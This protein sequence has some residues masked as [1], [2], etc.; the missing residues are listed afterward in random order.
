[1]IPNTKDRT[2][3]SGGV[4]KSGEFGIS[5]NDAAHIMTILRDTLYS[6][7]V[8]AVIR[9]YSANAWD[10]HRDSGI[11]EKPIKIQLPTD[12]DP[13]LRIRD[14]GKGLSQS[15]V[16]T[17]YTQYGASTKR[18]SDNSVGMLG[19]GSKSG[20]AYS[21]SFNITSWHG[22]SKR[23]YVAVLDKSEKGIIQQLHEEPCGEETGVE[24][25]LAIKPEDIKEFTDK[26]HELFKYFRPRPDIN[27]KLPEL[28]EAQLELKNG[29]IYD[30]P[31]TH[32]YYRSSNW[33]A[34]MGCVFYKISLEQLGEKVPEFLSNISGALFFNIGDVQINASREELKYSDHT[35]AALVAKFNLVVD[36][37]VSHTL[38]GIMSGNFSLWERRVKAQVFKRLKLPVPETSKDLVSGSIP[39]KQQERK[40][41]CFSIYQKKMGE[42]SSSISVSTDTRLIIRNDNKALTGYRLGQHDYIVQKLGQTPIAK[43]ETELDALIKELSLDGITIVKSSDVPWYATARAGSGGKMYNPKHRLKVFEYKGEGSGSKPYSRLWEGVDREPEDTDLYVVLEWFEATGF[44]SAAHED[45]KLAALCEVKIPPVYGYKTTEKHPVE[46]DELLGTHYLKWRVDW[47]KTLLTPKIRM[48]YNQWKWSKLFSNTYYWDE[49][50][51]TKNYKKVVE[52]V[53]ENHLIARTIKRHLD[54]KKYFKSKGI[55]NDTY[56]LLEKRLGDLIGPSDVDTVLASIDAKYPLF[57]PYELSKLWEEHGSK[58]AHYVKIIDQLENTNASTAVHS[59]ERVLDDCLGGKEPHSPEVL[60]ELQTAAAGDP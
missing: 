7:K 40:N 46:E 8:L 31:E 41:R 45:F 29:V 48:S 55:L 22:G 60:P 36:E 59:D 5:L 16:F 52:H 9:E 49:D 23:L 6:D 1:M 24:I 57:E 43:V 4:E 27:T 34:V 17:V 12:L 44:Y 32:S 18:N 51:A 50:R 56:E 35:K 11:P 10:S 58:W 20:F 14:F 15:D 26:S 37:Y 3:Q 25:Q 19:I 21:D 38:Q 33:V 28:P 42:L 54:A 30:D 13:T 39:L 47:A 53:G 2:I